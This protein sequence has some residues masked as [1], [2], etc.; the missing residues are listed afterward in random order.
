MATPEDRTRP[1]DD[2]TEA[3]HQDHVA[4]SLPDDQ[5]AHAADVFLE[6]QDPADAERVAEHHQEM[7]KLGAAVKGEGEIV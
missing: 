5:E 3:E 7:D 2:G 1:V 4:D 6:E